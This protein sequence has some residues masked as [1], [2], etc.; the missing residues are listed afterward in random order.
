ML[1]SR[2]EAGVNGNG[3]HGFWCSKE[4]VKTIAWLELCAL[5]RIIELVPELTLSE[6][7]RRYKR[8][9]MGL[10]AKGRMMRVKCFVDN[11]AVVYIMRSMVTESAEMMPELRL[12]NSVMYRT[13]I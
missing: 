2:M 3:T 12:L 4:R 8:S 10:A 13:R 1:R 11:T 5:R 7:R 9:E 6:Y